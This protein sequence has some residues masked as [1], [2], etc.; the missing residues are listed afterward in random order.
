MCIRDS[1]HTWRNPTEWDDTIMTALIGWGYPAS[2]V[3][4]LLLRSDSADAAR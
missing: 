1:T 3:E 2:D 4:R